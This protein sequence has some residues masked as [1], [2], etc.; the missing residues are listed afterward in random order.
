MLNTTGAKIATAAS[1]LPRPAIRV[2]I[3]ALTG[4]QGTMKKAAGIRSG[5][6]ALFAHWARLTLGVN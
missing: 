4:E 5:R 3:A 6:L 2:G 1:M